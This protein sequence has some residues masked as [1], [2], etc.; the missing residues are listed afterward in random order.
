MLFTRAL[1]HTLHWLPPA[2]GLSGGVLCV[3]DG[4]AALFHCKGKVSMKA[5]GDQRGKKVAFK[6]QSRACLQR[7]LCIF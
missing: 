5:G 4:A 3:I 6:K 2:P 1:L 7:G